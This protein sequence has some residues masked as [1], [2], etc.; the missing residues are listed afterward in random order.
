MPDNKCWTTQTLTKF[1]PWSNETQRW[2]RN[3]KKEWVR[4]NIIIKHTNHIGVTVCHYYGGTGEG[5]PTQPERDG[6]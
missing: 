1:C 6:V 3:R 2:V 4:E 5:H